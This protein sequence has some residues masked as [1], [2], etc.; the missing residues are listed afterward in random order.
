ME[1]EGHQAQQRP[2]PPPQGRSSDPSLSSFAVP[3][4]TAV[5]SSLPPPQPPIAPPSPSPAEFLNEVKSEMRLVARQLREAQQQRDDVI[6]L[7]DEEHDAS[8]ELMQL[9]GRIGE[10]ERRFALLRLSQA[11]LLRRPTPVATPLPSAASSLMGSPRTVSATNVSNS[12]SFTGAPPLCYATAATTPSTTSVMGAVNDVNRNAS[13]GTSLRSGIHE[14]EQFQNSN[15]SPYSFTSTAVAAGDP[16][17]A[18]PSL[19]ALAWSS[20]TTASP[21]LNGATTSSWSTALAQYNANNSSS[22]NC[23]TNYTGANGNGFEGSGGGSNDTMGEASAPYTRKGFSWEVYE[24]QVDLDA[25]SRDALSRTA[26]VELPVNPTQQYGGERFPWSTELRRMMREVFGLHDYRFCQLDIMNACMDARDVFVLLPTGGGKSLCYQLPALM[27]NPAQVTI[28]ISP[29]ISLIQDQ[30]YALIA[31]DIPAMALTGQTNDAARRSLFQEWAAGRVLHT[32]VYVTPEYFGRSDHFIGTLQSL[33]GQGLLCR[34]VI[35]EA[36]CVSQWGHDFR[37]DYRKLSVLKSQFP[38]IPIT[39]LTATAT[40]FVQQDV[41]KTLALRD[42]IIFK[43]SFNRSNLKYSVQHVQGKQVIAVVEDLVLHRFSPS[44]CGIVYCLSRK[45]CEEMASA[46]VRRGIKAS[47]YHSEASAKNERQEQWTRDELQVICATIAFGMGINKPD[48]RYVIHAAMPKS[49]EGYYQESGRAGRDGLPSDCVLLSAT[50][51]R[52]RQER[53]IHGS[54]DWRASLTSLHRML[55]YTLNDVDCRR[56]Q[57]LDHFGE[58]VDV[59]FCLTQRAAEEAAG[60]RGPAATS[61]TQ[62]C[63]NCASKLAEGWAVKE[64]NVNSILIDLYAIVQ[65][66]GA[67]TAKQLLGVYRGAVSEIGRAVEARMRVKGTPS[68]Y[69]NG[70]KQP[71]TLL[72]RALLQ[73]MQLGLFEER[74]DSVNDFAVCAFVEL[75]GGPA[76]QQLYRDIKAGKRVIVV[77]TRGEKAPSGK[78]DMSLGSNDINGVVAAAVAAGAKENSIT[79]EAFANARAGRTL[80]QKLMPAV[81]ATAAEDNVPLSVLFEGAPGSF[82]NACDAPTSRAKG[83]TAARKTKSAGTRRG[84]GYVLDEADADGDAVSSIDSDSDAEADLSNMS[85]FINDDSTSVSNSSNITDFSTPAASSHNTTPRRETDTGTAM[86][87]AQA[88]AGS[89]L[90]SLNDRAS[91]TSGQLPNASMRRASDGDPNSSGQQPRKRSRKE[92]AGTSAATAAPASTVPAARL[93]RL[94]V[95]LQEEMEQLVQTLVGQSVGCRSYNV[96]PKSTILRLTDTLA[97]PRWGT[98][99]DLMDLEGMGKN[100]VK[101]YGADI[102]RVYRRFRY[103]HIGDVNELTEQEAAEL[104]EVKTAVR[105][106]HRL[107]RGSELVVEEVVEEDNS[108]G[109]PRASSSGLQPISGSDSRNGSVA[110]TAGV[111]AM[112]GVAG[113]TH[114]LAQPSILLDPTTPDKTR[115]ASISTAGTPSQPHGGPL[116][117]SPGSGVVV[118]DAGPPQAPPRRTTF[119][120]STTSKPADGAGGGGANAAVDAGAPSTSSLVRPSLQVPHINV[121]SSAAA[122]VLPHTVDTLDNLTYDPSMSAPATASAGRAPTAMAVRGDGSGAARSLVFSTTSPPWSQQQQQVPPQQNHFSTASVSRGLPGAPVQFSAPLLPEP[123]TW[124][125]TLGAISSNPFAADA[126]AAAAASVAVTRA[127]V[128]PN[129]DLLTPYTPVPLLN[130]QGQTM[131]GDVVVPPPPVGATTYGYP[132]GDPSLADTLRGGGGVPL[133]VGHTPAFAVL[134]DAPHHRTAPSSTNNNINTDELLIGSSPMPTQQQR[135]QSHNVE[136]Y[137]LHGAGPSDSTAAHAESVMLLGSDGA[138]QAPLLPSPSS[139]I[140]SASNGSDNNGSNYVG[141]E[142]A[143][144]GGNAAAGRGRVGGDADTNSVDFLMNLCDDAQLR[145][146]LS[147]S[148]GQPSPSRLP[149]QRLYNYHYHQNNAT[150]ENGSGSVRGA[151]PQSDR[152]NTS[153]AAVPTSPSPLCS[154]GTDEEA[155]SSSERLL[156]Q[157]GT[158]QAAGSAK[159]TSQRTKRGSGDRLEVF[160]VDDDSE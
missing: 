60:V 83:A 151:A 9:D 108:N 122:A 90:P 70:G 82:G 89:R 123:P 11:T 57:Q 29:L 78:G 36:H 74:L 72:E 71:K 42:A 149:P 93:E 134:G 79:V 14:G 59:H 118:D 33:A 2:P 24:Q 126:A 150:R 13:F 84:G 30:V 145:T 28:V 53:L 32:L 25:L 20:S 109:T 65:R 91:T 62:L 45:D 157:T 160:T 52:Q 54:K 15:N 66:L 130:Q 106:R 131:A 21:A 85:S 68:E 10:L 50:T 110:A 76:A 92:K 58:A 73:A 125:S 56:R 49:I 104:K 98:V 27:P 128:H 144:Q 135:Q 48:V 41:I 80:R 16:S 38:S 26:H 143:V 67:L 37:P 107:V 19:P 94:K 154:T 61:V 153:G 22:M 97:V 7:E 99:D 5:A 47:Y 119:T 81:P 100:K 77:R 34:F 129:M 46:L 18:V 17:R 55:S 105:P 155:M 148:G 4:P 12:T 142:L 102:L 88:L 103:L 139:F 140:P 127:H 8:A 156:F 136:K 101:R 138:T 44:S 113:V 133:N 35:D 69:K 39:A 116:G 6:L 96:M 146:P 40:D 152:L 75:G 137:G 111:L 115:T 43:G 51:D 112:A 132:S 147:G 124:P 64:V 120:F 31:N 158:P 1:R 86:R 114:H 3:S 141:T 159:P 117:R 87:R 63:D 121:A 95:L 23:N